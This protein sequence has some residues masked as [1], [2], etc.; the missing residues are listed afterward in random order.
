METRERHLSPTKTQFRFSFCKLPLKSSPRVSLH[1]ARESFAFSG[2]PER[3]Q[4][5]FWLFPKKIAL[6]D[7]SKVIYRL[8]KT[9]RL[10]LVLWVGSTFWWSVFVKRNVASEEAHT[11]RDDG[12]TKGLFSLWKLRGSRAE[13]SV[14]SIVLSGSNVF[15]TDVASKVTITV[16][17]VISAS[18][19]LNAEVG[20]LEKEGESCCALKLTEITNLAQLMDA[21]FGLLLFAAM[22]IHFSQVNNCLYNADWASLT[23]TPTKRY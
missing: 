13:E 12:R 9:D 8:G 6:N 20:S 22:K 10:L 19:Y 14:L 2:A 3:F 4:A 18:C 23:P 21:N 15:Q 11:F 7:V 17:N 1:I 16:S 5:R